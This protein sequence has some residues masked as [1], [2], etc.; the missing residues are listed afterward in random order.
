MSIDEV[1]ATAMALPG[2]TEGERYGTRTWFVGRKGFAWERPF[3]KA[4]LKRFG[5]APPPKGPILAVSVGDLDEKEAIL[6]EAP[7]GVFTISHFDGYAALLIQLDV[8]TKGVIREL[9]IDAW[10]GSAPRAVADE[11]VKNARRHRDR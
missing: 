2:V 7:K 11:Y 4:D 1:A 8:A 3:S 5:T 9:V 10:L 6:A